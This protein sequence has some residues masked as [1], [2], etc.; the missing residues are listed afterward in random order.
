MS[1][2][3]LEGGTLRVLDGRDL[4]QID[5]Y[6]LVDGYVTIDLDAYES[7]VV[8]LELMMSEDR[9]FLSLTKHAGQWYTYENP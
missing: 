4:S 6:A 5:S 2:G 7:D 8:L 1:G 3:F 9:T